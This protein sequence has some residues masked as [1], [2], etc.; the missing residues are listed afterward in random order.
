MSGGGGWWCWCACGKNGFLLNYAG[1]NPGEV[2]AARPPKERETNVD[3]GGREF[4][5][6]EMLNQSCGLRMSLAVIFMGINKT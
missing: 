2:T 6:C 5:L 3:G 1:V 4:I